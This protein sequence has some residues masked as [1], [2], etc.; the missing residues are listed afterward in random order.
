MARIE[1]RFIDDAGRAHGE[2]IAAAIADLSRLVLGSRAGHSSG[3]VSSIAVVII[4]R[5]EDIE[6]IFAELDANTLATAGEVVSL[7][8]KRLRK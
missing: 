4:E 3:V 7:L 1:Q 6:R 5:R 2:P 8:S